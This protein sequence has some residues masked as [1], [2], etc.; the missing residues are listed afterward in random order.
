MPTERTTL[1]DLAA[2][3]E[4]GHRSEAASTTRRLRVPTLEERALIL[5]RA[6]EGREDFTNDE[7]TAARKTILDAM[8]TEIASRSQI[9]TPETA[10]APTEVAPAAIAPAGIESSDED[11]LAE[12]AQKLQTHLRVAGPQA[13]RRSKSRT[14]ILYLIVAV[15]VGLSVLGAITL[16][17]ITVDWFHAL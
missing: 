12:M 1:L 13:P 3:T 2:A 15:I 16:V 7:H 9:L 14:L 4:S 10:S 6:T 8:A 5:L 11:E 17:R